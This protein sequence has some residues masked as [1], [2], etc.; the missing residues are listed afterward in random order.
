MN[1]VSKNNLVIHHFVGWWKYDE[2]SNIELE[3]A[4]N[5]REPECS[6]LLAGALYSIDFQSMTQIRCR[7]PTRRRRVRRDTPLFPAKGITYILLIFIRF[8]LIPIL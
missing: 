2:R 6:L 7:D 3:T 4:F 5:S 1:Y 8:Y